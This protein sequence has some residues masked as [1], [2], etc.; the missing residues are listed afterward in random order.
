AAGACSPRRQP[1]ESD[2]PGRPTD[3]RPSGPGTGRGLLHRP[4]PRPAPGPTRTEGLCI[5]ALGEVETRQA[6]RP[7]LARPRL[8]QRPR[9]PGETAAAVDA[10]DGPVQRGTAGLASDLLTTTRAWH[11]GGFADGVIRARQSTHQA[12]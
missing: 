10:L 6:H 3:H 4:S 7:C 11:N 5:M 1:I 2:P 9:P 8:D 12:S